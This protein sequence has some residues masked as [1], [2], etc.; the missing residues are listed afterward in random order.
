MYDLNVPLPRLKSK[1]RQEFERQRFV[2]DMTMRN[3]IYAL[4]WME[5]QET[6]NF[7]KQKPHVMKYFDDEFE[8]EKRVPKD[9]FVNKFIKGTA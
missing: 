9:S 2:Q 8:P 3:R 4:G 6:V 5:F 1:I 7:W